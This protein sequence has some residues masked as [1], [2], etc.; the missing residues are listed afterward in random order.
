MTGLKFGAVLTVKG[1]QAMPD[2]R[3]LWTDEAPHRV[4]H[5]RALQ[6]GLAACGEGV[7]KAL[8]SA[9]LDDRPGSADPDAQG[10]VEEDGASAGVVERLLDRENVPRW[11]RSRGPRRDTEAMARLQRHGSL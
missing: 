10:T 7:L 1:G 4:L 6:P 2:L 11:P 3:S 8:A 5:G 9:R